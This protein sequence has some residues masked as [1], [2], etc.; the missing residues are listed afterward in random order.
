MNKHNL[1]V[2]KINRILS[3]I[4]SSLES[5]FNK[6]RFSKKN[7]FF[8]NNRVF[9][10]ISAVVILTLSYFFIP[11]MYDKNL[12]KSEIKNQILKKYNIDINFNEKIRYGLIPKPHF[13]SKNL[14]ILRNKKEIGFVENFK[15]F[16]SINDFFKFNKVEIKD[17]I[18]KKA[19]FNMQ[20]ED[21]VFF[22]N[23]LKTDPNENRIILKKSN[24]FFKGKNDELLFLNKINFGEF[25][26]D[27]YNLENVFKSK[28]EIFNV[29]YKFLIKNDKFNKN[30]FSK[31]KSNKI[32]LD[33]EN[34]IN[35][36]DQVKKGF[37]DLLFINKNI[38]LEYFIK[39][40]SLEFFTKN[41]KIL[42][43][44]IDF[45]PFYLKA[46]LNYDGI[47]IKDL[48][49]NESILIDLIKSEI[50]NNQNLNVN[51]NLS[52]TDII[53]LNELNNLRL[54]LGLEQ[55]DITLSKSKIMWKDDIEIIL[56][57]GLV[58]YD[59]DEIS[60]IGKLQINAKNINDFYKSFQIKKIHRKQLNQIE[61]DF[62]YS[63]NG[64]KFKF[65]NIKI[66]NSSNTN[67]DVFIN[68]Y[69]SSNK[70]FLNKI[71]FKNFINS[72][73]KIYAG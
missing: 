25:Y 22:E 71:T 16:I 61:L 8:K 51:I 54:N 34:D 63:F 12:I 3:S 60:L 40:N 19:D 55:G 43:G 13:V 31:F 14:S 33:I 38:S 2:K 11:T 28:N 68:N 72:F 1:L 9:F 64:N 37:L 50:F 23:L 56:S 42:D 46:N 32:R 65:S 24:L 18:F 49:A 10:G 15:I 4:N 59:K 7:E 45:K 26:Y 5:Y 70:T 41:K 29:P 21:V 69:N 35:Y 66:D 44:F 48:F 39:K 57:E 27:S 17:L 36:E 6:F 62:I 53:N 52:V 30:I 73:F 47:S 58:N 67:L 20:Q